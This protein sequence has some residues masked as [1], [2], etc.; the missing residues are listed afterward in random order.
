MPTLEPVAPGT[1]PSLGDA[2]AR[3]PETPPK[4]KL[5]DELEKLGPRLDD[6]QTRMFADG[7]RGLLV[8]LQARDAGGK[9][10]V[11]RHVFGLFNPQGLAIRSFGVPTPV[12]LSHDYLWR[13][14]GAMGPRGLITVFNRSHYEDVL[15]VRVHELVPKAVWQK[16]Y[17]QINAFESMLVDNGYAILKFFLHVSRD[18][19]R[20]RLEARLDDETKNW[21]FRAGDLEERARWDDYTAAYGDMLSRCS[22]PDAPWFVVPADSKPMRDLLIAQTVA[23]SLDSM[24]LTYP[25]ADPAVLAFRG[26]VK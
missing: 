3:L 26:K 5:R 6:L 17:A 4:D 23:R 13:A 14:H 18:E 25:P 9:D 10:G 22:T 16:R 21:K 1:T 8:V 15:V 24:E 7:K 19:Q 12:E 20:E 2:D 11:V